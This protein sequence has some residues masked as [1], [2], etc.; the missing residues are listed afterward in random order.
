M[1]WANLNHQQLLVLHFCHW[2]LP[3]PAFPELVQGAQVA[4]IN[5]LFLA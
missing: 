2:H 5:L 4:E 3:D 1:R